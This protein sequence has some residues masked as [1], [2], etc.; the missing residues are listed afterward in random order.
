MQI[1]ISSIH[2]VI[3]DLGGVII[4]LSEEKT[5]AGFSKLCGWDIGRLQ[6]EMLSGDLHKNFEKG[7][8]TAA[9][10]RNGVRD[11]LSIDSSDY[12]IDKAMNA[13]LLDIPKPRLELLESLRHTHQLFL[14]SNTNEIHWKRFN[15]ILKETTGESTIDVYFQKAYYSH[16][17]NLRK[18]DPKIFQLVLDENKLNPAETLFL[19]D[20]MDN[21]EGA[22]SLGINTVHIKNPAQLFELFL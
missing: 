16:H 2:H 8:I 19:D 13:M 9:E 12:Q 14:L 7:N 20:N 21:L 11:L 5:L 18:P 6:I 15:E 17:V 3:F 10:F 1:S 4:N 22:Q